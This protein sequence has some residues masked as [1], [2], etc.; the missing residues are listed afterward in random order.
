MNRNSVMRFP[1][2]SQTKCSWPLGIK[3]WGEEKIKREK[4]KGEGEACLRL[5]LSGS[6]QRFEELSDVPGY[7]SSLLRPVRAA[8][9]NRLPCPPP[10]GV[11]RTLRARKTHLR[12]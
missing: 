5:C 10:Q 2:P 3:G 6:Y 8:Q 7:C 1:F 4:E 12:L 9:G 11:D